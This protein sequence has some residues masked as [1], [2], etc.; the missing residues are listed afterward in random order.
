MSKRCISDIFYKLSKCSKLIVLFLSGK[1][2]LS[3]LYNNNT[4]CIFEIK[5]YVDKKLT[6]AKKIK[7][8][9]NM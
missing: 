9:E 1:K 5:L 2:V 7:H 6:D 3:K 4:H 8:F